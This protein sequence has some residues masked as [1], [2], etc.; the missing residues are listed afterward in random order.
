MECITLEENCNFEF[1][2]NKKT[3]YGLKFSQLSHFS[4]YDR[5]DDVSN[6]YFITFSCIKFHSILWN[7]ELFIAL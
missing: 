1:K 3:V 4:I 5:D 2:I 7:V 6:E